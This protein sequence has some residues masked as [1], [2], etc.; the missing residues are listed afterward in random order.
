MKIALIIPVNHALRKTRHES[1][2]NCYYEICTKLIHQNVFC[3]KLIHEICTKLRN[4]ICPKLLSESIFSK[5]DFESF[6]RIRIEENYVKKIKEGPSDLLDWRSALRAGGLL[7]LWGVKK[8]L[9][10]AVMAL[11]SVPRSGGV[12]IIN[13]FFISVDFISTY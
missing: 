8:H 1:C 3:T 6:S 10:C 2:T 7:S 11:V 9:H 13:I 4:E 12:I 5:I